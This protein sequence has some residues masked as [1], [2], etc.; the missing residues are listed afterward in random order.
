MPLQQGGIDV[1]GEEWAQEE[2]EGEQRE[3]QQVPG[4]FG[5]PGGGRG[6]GMELLQENQDLVG[7]REVE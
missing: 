1:R 4:G 5:D 3:L 2:K 7:L 6:L